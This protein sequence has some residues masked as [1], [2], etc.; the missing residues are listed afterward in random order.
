MKPPTASPSGLSLVELLT[1]LA[2]V[3]IVTAV[4][5]PN[6]TNISTSANRVKN[7]QNAQYIV[8]VASAVRA[9]G[10]TNAWADEDALI[11]DLSVGINQRNMSFS[12]SPLGPE[13]ITGAKEYFYVSGNTA[14]YEPEGRPPL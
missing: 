14:Y 9:A 13:E 2:V 12:I 1:T 10:Y 6:I 11:D 4:A 8:S 3:G 7:Q 5:L